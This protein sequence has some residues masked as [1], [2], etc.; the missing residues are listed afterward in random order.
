MKNI[1]KKL[2][3]FLL[4]AVMLMSMTTAVMAGIEYSVADAYEEC[5]ELYPEFVD[6]IKAEG[7]SDDKII[8][9]LETLQQYLLNLDVEITEENF[10]EYI[11]EA[12]NYAI[13]LRKHIAVRNALV[14]AFPGAVVDGI[15]GIV[16]E[17]FI[18]L[19]ETIKI[20]SSP[21]AC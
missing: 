18:P 12:V 13:T 1:T 20:S 21:T 19:V 16:N 2:I 8:A 10:E 11:I 14:N 3:S 6:K 17:E 9:F 7:I 4:A 15:D 5:A